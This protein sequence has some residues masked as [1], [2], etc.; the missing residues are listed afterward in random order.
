MVQEKFYFDNPESALKKYSEGKILKIFEDYLDTNFTVRATTER[1]G[2][3]G[4]LRYAIPFMLTDEGCRYCT[5]KYY[6]KPKRSRLGAKPYRY[7]LNC[8]HFEDKGTACN[9]K[10]CE[11][12]EK[13]KKKKK[14]R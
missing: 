5:N 6:N 9:C 13:E 7:C 1:Y 8:N 12:E 11:K 2:I 3:E 14:K 4:S 10:G